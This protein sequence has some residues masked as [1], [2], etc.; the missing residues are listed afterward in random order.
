MELQGQSSSRQSQAQSSSS[1]SS[2]QLQSFKFP[3]SRRILEYSKK[4]KVLEEED[5]KQ[6]I[7]DC[8]TCLMAECGDHVTKEQFKL[9]SQIICDKVPVLKDVEPLNW[10]KDVEFDSSVSD[11]C[12][13]VKG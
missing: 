11:L 13:S 9:A 1:K 12:C 8:M 2:N 3:I 4:G 6:L 5:R 10:P 7:R